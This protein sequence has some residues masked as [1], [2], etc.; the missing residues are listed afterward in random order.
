[1]TTKILRSIAPLKWGSSMESTFFGAMTVALQF[2]GE[3]YDYFD[4]MG[5]STAAFNLKFHTSWCPSSPDDSIG[6]YPEYIA[7]AFGYDF[8]FYHLLEEGK[9]QQNKT[10]FNKKKMLKIIQKE[11]TDN[12]PVLAIDLISPPD[13]GVITGFEDDKL[14]GRTYHDTS[15]DYSIAKNFPWIIMTMKPNKEA[16]I[17]LD[18]IYNSLKNAVKL[19]YTNTINTHY[20]CGLKAY[21][22]WIKELRDEEKITELDEEKFNFRW[23]VNAW[24]YSSLIDARHA[25]AEYLN[26]VC[27]EFSKSD[28]EV[29]KEAAE[30]L[31]DIKS[32]LFENWIYF[33]FKFWVKEKENKIWIP[34]DRFVEGITWSTEMRTKGAEVLEIVKDEEKKV[35][36]L[37]DQVEM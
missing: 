26:R 30:T 2:L 27:P 24:I 21:E 19:F 25:A 10:D 1:M 13:W 23:H 22:Y 4:L 28:A 35:F 29:I 20:T 16:P 15:K 7:N 36:D 11:I 32:I 8:R 34:T 33:P 6:P 3:P 9:K 14:L 37:L 18:S 31:E 5:L 12:R 17:L